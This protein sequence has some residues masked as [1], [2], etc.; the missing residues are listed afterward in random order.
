MIGAAV[1]ILTATTAM[2]AYLGMA[3]LTIRNL[4][5]EIRDRLRCAAAEN[6]R[7]ME[8]EARQALADRYRNRLSPQEVVKKL[9]RLNAGKTP[10]M[11]P[12]MLASEILVAGRRVEALH[13]SGLISRKE[14]VLWDER[15]A[16][17]EA[18]LSEVERFAAEK[19]NWPKKRS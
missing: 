10:R 12:K 1:F 3:T 13:E 16:R 7:S 17:K 6:R 19:R 18:A 4:P 11:A 14:K 15:I 9:Q 8:E 5:E 2:L